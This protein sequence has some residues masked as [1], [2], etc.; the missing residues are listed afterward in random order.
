MDGHT[1]EIINLFA[2]LISLCIGIKW[3]LIFMCFF[4]SIKLSK[5]CLLD[6]KLQKWLFDIRETNLM[7]FGR[8]ILSIARIY[9][10]W[11]TLSI[12][13]NTIACSLL[14]VF[15]MAAAVAKFLLLSVLLF[16]VVLMVWVIRACE[17]EE[18]SSLVS[19]AIVFATCLL[20]VRGTGE[21]ESVM[22]LLLERCV[23][24]LGLLSGEKVL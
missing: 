2:G 21:E 6:K 15:S 22:F 4:V 18:I 17:S 13:L 1:L 11:G 3:S 24:F 8:T 20:S 9:L 12:E 10:I 23:V 5:I 14:G 19:D 7:F 16:D